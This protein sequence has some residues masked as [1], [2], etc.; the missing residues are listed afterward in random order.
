MKIFFGVVFLSIF[1]IAIGFMAIAYISH[2]NENIDEMLNK[3][4]YKGYKGYKKYIESKHKEKYIAKEPKQFE[5]YISKNKRKASNKQEKR[6]V[7]A[8]IY[9]E[10]NKKRK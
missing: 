9:N 1:I 10:L 6:M 3:K 2:I 4:G 8:Y 5:N 7:D